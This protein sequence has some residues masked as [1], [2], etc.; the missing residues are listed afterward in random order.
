MSFKIESICNQPIIPASR[1]LKRKRED[2]SQVAEVGHQVLSNPEN[3]YVSAPPPKKLNTADSSF[4]FQS[5]SVNNDSNMRVEQDFFSNLQLDI[6]N[7]IL[8]HLPLKALLR[9]ERVSRSW[10]AIFSS[11]ENPLWI[12]YKK[13]FFPE[14]LPLQQ[15]FDDSKSFKENMKMR[16]PTHRLGKEFALIKKG[17]TALKH[18][19]INLPDVKYNAVIDSNVSPQSWD[20]FVTSLPFSINTPVRTVHE[21]TDTLTF[22]LPHDDDTHE[23][24]T[25][26]FF[27]PVEYTEDKKTNVIWHKKLTLKRQKGTNTIKDPVGI[28]GWMSNEISLPGFIEKE[29]RRKGY[30]K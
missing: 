17:S 29:L 7:M 16:F 8:D 11:R 22:I 12:P 15:P 23:C 25:V 3:T 28:V 30:M 20:F 19:L 6:K 1:G 9:L 13:T 10:Q 14:D 2:S 27:G 18:F 21:S 24:R 26:L 5:L 4:T